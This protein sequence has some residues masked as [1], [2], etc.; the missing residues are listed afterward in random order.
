MG[1]SNINSSSKIDENTLSTTPTNPLLQKLRIVQGETV[2]LPSRGLLYEDG[3]LDPNVTDGEVRISPMTI[4]DEIL[5]RSPDALLSG[6]AIATVIGRCVPQILKPLQLH[7]SDL[8]FIFLA[9][10][11]VSYGPELEVNYKHDCEHAKEH[12][13]IVS[14]DK[15]LRDCVYLDPLTI[16]NQYV[17]YVE[18]TDQTV[19]FKPIRTQDMIDILSPQAEKELTNAEIEQ[20]MIKLAT[21]Q[22]ISIDGETGRH[23]ILEWAAQ[24]PAA[25]MRSIRLKLEGMER[26]GVSYKFDL[27]CRDCGKNLEAEVPLNTVSFFM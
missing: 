19:I 1:F 16:E 20:E 17:L 12:S 7:Y 3:I 27:T 18:E 2:R 26:W 22:I 24:V 6:E 23:N 15:K 13:Y 4:R 25:V 5:M 14:I 10:R 11:K 8:D 21:T 9:L